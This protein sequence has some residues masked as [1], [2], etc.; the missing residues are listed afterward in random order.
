[1]TVIARTSALFLDRAIA[2]KSAIGG[3]LA[4]VPAA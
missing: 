2:Q 1:M 4:R 3:F